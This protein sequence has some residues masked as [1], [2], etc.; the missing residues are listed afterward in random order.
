MRLHIICRILGMLLIL[1][2][3]TLI[4]P[5]LVSMYY[6]DNVTGSFVAAQLITLFSGIFLWAPTRHEKHELRVRDGFLV[7]SLFWIVLS[8]FG[9]L[10]FILSH[11]PNLSI[12]DAVFESTSGLTTTGATVITGLD[13]LPKGILYYRQCMACF[14]GFIY[15]RMFRNSHVGDLI[16][17]NQK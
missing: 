16:S 14:H 8:L 3:F 13:N 10:P 15:C 7:T 9:A 11:A 2:S 12:T 17:A 5:I 1:F 4:P 6:S